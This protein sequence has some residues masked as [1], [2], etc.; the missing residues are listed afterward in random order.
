MKPRAIAKTELSPHARLLLRILKDHARGTGQCWPG[1]QRLAELS[2]LSERTVRRHLAAL[3][4]AGLVTVRRSGLMRTNRYHLRPSV[5]GQ[6]RPSVS[7][8]CE[9]IKETQRVILSSKAA[10]EESART[11]GDLQQLG[12]DPA[13]ARQRV[14][15]YGRLA[16]LVVA[17]TRE[18]AE[19]RRPP[20]ESPVGYAENI[21]AEPA[22][23]G[24][25]FDSAGQPIAPPGSKVAGRLRRLEAKAEQE[26]KAEAE[27]RELDVYLAE[28]D[29]RRR[30]RE[31]QWQ[32]LTEKQR[33][34]IVAHIRE[35]KPLF[36][37]KQVDGSFTMQ[38]MCYAEMERRYGA[39]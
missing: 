12:Y 9:L 35:T 18:R 13:M 28:E 10:A 23:Y 6:D 36:V 20:L 22:K 11:I 21:F 19:R 15:A 4:T 37:H 3:V 16:E 8:Q 24:V 1:Q 30:R 29:V 14:E 38:I 34:S 26:S 39:Q 5:S 17:L 31:A 32:A 7:G 27:K 25:T 2:G 33:A